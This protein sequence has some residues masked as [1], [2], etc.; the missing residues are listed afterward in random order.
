VGA[1]DFSPLVVLFVLQFVGA[2]LRST[3]AAM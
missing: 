3:L 1:F 2:I